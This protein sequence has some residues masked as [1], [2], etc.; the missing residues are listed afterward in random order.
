LKT[1]IKGLFRSEQHQFQKLF[2][3][4]FHVI[5]DYQINLLFFNTAPVVLN[6]NYC[7]FFWGLLVDM[8]SSCE[9]PYWNVMLSLTCAN[10]CISTTTRY[11]E[12]VP[13]LLC[14]D[15]EGPLVARSVLPG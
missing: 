4:T 7:H 9:C 14:N 5:S 12:T 3:I 11:S 6:Q 1:L 2:V 10:G 13:S 15:V 8:T